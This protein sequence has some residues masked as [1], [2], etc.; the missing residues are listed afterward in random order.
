MPKNES[1]SF[2]SSKSHKNSTRDNRNTD[3]DN[4][5]DGNNSGS[6]SEYNPSVLDS[7]I[8]S[9]I[10][11]TEHDVNYKIQSVQ[12]PQLRDLLDFFNDPK[13]INST[14][15]PTTNI[16]DRLAGK[17]YN[18][19]DKKISKLFALLEMCR[20][21]KIRI[22]MNEKQQLYSG[23]MLDFDIYQDTENDQ[24]TDEIIYILCQKIIDILMKILQ[25][26]ERK[27]TIYLGI[28]RRP[29]ITYNDEKDCYK[30]GFHLLIPG[31]KV[32]KG[33]KKYI[34]KSLL[35]ND[36]I[37]QIMGEV[38]PADIKIKNET[39]QRNDFLDKNSPNVPVHMLG[40]STKKGHSPYILSHIYE[41]TI[42][43]DT[44]NVV[45]IKN[46]QMMKKKNINLCYEFSLNWECPG[47]FIKKHQYEIQEKYISEIE[48]LEQKNRNSA[49]EELS[50]NYGELSLNAI[51]DAKIKEIKDL[52][53]TLN[54]RRAE[55]YESWFDVLCV[56]ANTSS[57]YK[58]LA[59]YF[60]RKSKKF[61]LVD[62]EKVWANLSKVNYYNSAVKKQ[63]TLGSLHYWA[64]LDNPERYEQIR[65]Q[66]VYNILY[67]MVYE[68]YKEGILTHADIA[69]L[70]HTLLQHKYV[71][72]EPEGERKRVWYEFI[73]D[74][75]D[76]IEG[77]LYKWHKHPDMPVS[78]SRYISEI[79]PRLFDQVFKNVKKNY[80][81]SSGDISKYYNKVLQNFKA[82]MRK[83]GDRLFKKNVILEA[84]DKF[85]KRGF[86]LNLD[87]DPLSRGVRNGILKLSLAPSGHPIL[88]KGY[89]NH[90]I[91]KFTAAPYIPFDPYDPITKKLLIALRNLYPDNEPDSFN[92]TMSFLASTIDGNPKESMFMILVGKG[93]NG[94]TFLV[95][96]HKGAIG[97]HYG[98]KMPLSFLT[99]KSTSA[100]Q[101]TPALMLIK[102]ASFAYYSES[103]KHERLN[104][105]RVK[106]VTGLETLS[107]RKNYGDQI[108]FKP[109]CHHL[110]T[111]NYDFDIDCADYGTW[112]RIEYNLLKITFINLNERKID[113]ND[114]YQRVADDSVTQSWAEDPEIQGRYLGIMVWYHYFLYR[115]YH[116]KVKA[117][118]HPHIAFETEKYRRRQ[119]I[120]T[121][122]LSQRLV[123]CADEK[124]MHPMTDEVQKYIR[125]HSANI[126]PLT[127]SKGITDQFQNSQIGNFVKLTSRGLFLV[128]HKFLDNGEQLGERETYAM[129]NVFDI[130]LPEDNFGIQ[131]ETPEMYYENIC[132]EYDKY[133][134]VFNNESSYNVD[135]NMLL[136]MNNV[137][138]DDLKNSPEI[139]ENSRKDNIDI[140]GRVLPSGIVLKAL[141]EPSLNYLT[142]DYHMIGCDMSGY[143]PYNEIE[144]GHEA[145]NDDKGGDVD[146]D[147]KGGDVDNDDKGGDVDNDDKGGDVDTDEEVEI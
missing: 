47:G 127:T 73:L 33:V 94:K 74:D 136:F 25:F 130:A 93:S 121:S 119:D 126:G 129:K 144:I 11:I 52:L 21:N 51:H 120:I 88:I 60:S 125:W 77:E 102:D 26:K 46:E 38:D 32:T 63:L 87:K 17:C 64:K 59:E 95:E 55:E 98:K 76:Y 69:Q 147:D 68:G 111:T 82:T 12:S 132:K 81:K 35:D 4:D 14:G 31:I 9:E 84:E 72:D 141:E 13:M 122:F 110:V 117:V 118:P 18:V 49:E 5:D 15:D 45:L 75:D 70:L 8:D 78:I 89:H 42:N 39:Y 103:D 108:N 105:A 44:K 113:E 66:N 19:P 90:H 97:D 54:I 27:E 56:L 109:R 142:D 131:I 133:K 91:S 34:I 10:G 6:E 115:K 28:T 123:K 79:L 96:L 104:A 146:N 29:S 143:L 58:T 22:M 80:E 2:K 37:N 41:A 57:S 24:I 23:I 53:D 139:K 62:F 86:S 140:N 1:K 124:E 135:A 112:R 20:R 92:F 50:R 61:K 3:N 43:T 107:G 100:D 83:L 71:T 137:N 65:K 30:D 114:P 138:A 145:D 116:G 48:E 85:N 99:T 101:A 7:D 40:S 36:F 67:S 134:H 106:E 128:G 16:V